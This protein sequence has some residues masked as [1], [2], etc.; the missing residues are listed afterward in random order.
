ME[1]ILPEKSG[2]AL[3]TCIAITSLVGRLIFG[4]IS[5]LPIVRV[6]RILLQQ[7]S[8]LSIGIC[9]MLMAAAPFFHGFNFES[10]ILFSLIF[11]LFDGCN[12][13]QIVPIA[14]DIC[15]HSGQSQAIGFLLGLSSIPVTFGPYIAG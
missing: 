7:V 6:N 15:G 2:G 4:Y 5:D 10:L 11:G 8:F 3:L 14:I 9:T 12:E 1:D 13:P